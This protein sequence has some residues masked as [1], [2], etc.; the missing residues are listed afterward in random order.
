[1]S[2]FPW[3][4]RPKWC[5][6]VKLEKFHFERFYLELIWYFDRKV[7]KQ[8]GDIMG[9]RHCG[10]REWKMFEQKRLHWILVEPGKRKL[11][12][13]T[14]SWNK[15]Q[16]KILVSLEAMGKVEIP[17]PIWNIKNLKRIKLRQKMKFLPRS[18]S[19]LQLLKLEIKRLL[20]RKRK[21]NDLISVQ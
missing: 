11:S 20:R 5:W 15:I 4:S 9:R 1:M 12:K 6:E 14:M 19:K 21:S 17:N 10:M 2:G 16:Q 3:F 18:Q 13:S 7:R 8:D